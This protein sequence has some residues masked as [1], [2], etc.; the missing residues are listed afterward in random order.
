MLR[1]FLDLLQTT[2][3][4]A[5]GAQ[6]LPVE[7]KRVRHFAIK[8]QHVKVSVPSP[9]RNHVV[10]SLE[11]FVLTTHRY[12]RSN[13]DETGAVATSLWHN[14]KALIAVL[15]DVD[16]RYDTVTLPLVYSETYA[17]LMESG[18]KQFDQRSFVTV[19]KTI[20]YGCVS[21]SLLPM[22]RK[23]EV[24]SASK[25]QSEISHGRERGTK[26]FAAEMA[27]AASIPE[28]VVVSCRVYDAVD[29]SLTVNV[30]CSLDIKLPEMEIR[31][32]PLPNELTRVVAETQA[33]IH[34]RLVS[35]WGNADSVFYGTP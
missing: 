17:W 13:Y 35:E 29:I 4:E 11:S 24:A 28:I 2:A 1:E 7:D 9:P 19:L 22:I 5:S 20:L 12:G 10:Q 16:D 8:G 27:N 3:V 14:H 30:K 34:D 21:D 26:E 31:F 6:A 15:D 18:R 25:M 33:F 23:V 32:I